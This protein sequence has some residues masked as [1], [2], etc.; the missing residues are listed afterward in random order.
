VTEKLSVDVCVIGAGSGGLTVAAFCAMVGAPVVLIEKG[1]MGGD[2]LNVGC[3]PSKA[4]VAA[5][6]RA[7]DHRTAAAFG[8]GDGRVAINVARVRDHIRE[9]IAAIAPTDSAARFGALG[10]RVIRAAARFTGPNTVEA[11]GFTITARRF[12]VATGSRPAVP[13]IEGLDGVAF[14]TNET[15]FDL[16]E[17]PRHLAVIGG[18]PVGLEVTIF[19]QDRILAG[20][21]PEMTDVVR[22]ALLADRITLHEASRVVR[23]GVDGADIRVHA[24]QG[25]EEGAIGVSHLLVAV[26]RKANVE[27]LGLEA[28]GITSGPRGITVDGGLR[29]TNS[30]VYAIGDVAGGAAFTHVAGWHGSMVAQNILFRRP[31]RT[32]RTAIP[33][34]TLT[35][36][37]LAHI[38]LTEA[39][40]L[41]QNVKG[42]RILRW[43]FAENDRATATR[44]RAG[45]VKLMVGHKGAI[46]GCSI[47]GHGA[48]ELIAPYAVALAK[49]MTV[50]ELSGIVLPYPTLS[51]AG[52]RA[53]GTYFLASLANPWVGRIVRFLRRFG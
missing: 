32:D 37:E 7:E 46:L 26:G 24:V 2:C 11:G 10:V 42:L 8:V 38:G 12:V 9:T 34:V 43:P 48:G 47:A 49:G 53:A 50:G 23:V 22:R 30:R 31:V 25:G 6:Q 40:A 14:L 3:V 17:C 36:P 28:A 18:G 15:V 21:D 44:R 51:E 39:E 45:H 33:R 41:K 16:G 13:P 4:L 52:K 35:D 19:E 20:E 1:E 29:T 5:A 27:D